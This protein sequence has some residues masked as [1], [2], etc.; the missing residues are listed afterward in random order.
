[1]FVSTPLQAGGSAPQRKR[2]GRK[3]KGQRGWFHWPHKQ[4]Q[5]QQPQAGARGVLGQGAGGNAAAQPSL[6]QQQPS[7]LMQRQ[8]S[9]LMQQQQQ[10]YRRTA[11]RSQTPAVGRAV[12]R[13]VS[14][15]PSFAL[16]I[17]DL[18]LPNRWVV[19]G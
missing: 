11:S 19:L 12:S 18:K 8:P 9:L 7:L 1:M 4:Q 13:A 16:P 6:L 14:V 17:D 15:K 5:Q 2:S 3:Q 10:Q